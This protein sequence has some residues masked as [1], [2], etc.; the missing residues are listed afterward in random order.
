MY[1]G[2]TFITCWLRERNPH[3]ATAASLA[4]DGVYVALGGDKGL[5]IAR[6]RSGTYQVGAMLRLPED[7]SVEQAALLDDPDALRDELSQHYA[8]WSEP[9]RNIIKNIEGTF[10]TWPQYS[11][12]P[13]G[14]QW[15]HVP[16]VTLIG[17]A[18]HLT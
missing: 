8:G 6:L 17:D 3:H 7:W 10:H 5:V 14:L 1:H 4:S 11:L 13:A 12:P 16:G 9:L 18:A 15:E 2:V